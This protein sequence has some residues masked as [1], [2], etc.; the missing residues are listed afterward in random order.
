MR[1]DVIH[2]IGGK[3]Q[4]KTYLDSFY[5]NTKKL[6]FSGLGFLLI[7]SGFQIDDLLKNA[8]FPS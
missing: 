7:H 1:E 4:S 2:W 5:S 8:I 6:S 3:K